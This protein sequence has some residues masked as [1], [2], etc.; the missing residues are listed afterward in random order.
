MPIGEYGIHRYQSEEELSEDL[1]AIC[2]V[3]LVGSCVTYVPSDL[4]GVYH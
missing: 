3:S 2:A 4:T 1:H